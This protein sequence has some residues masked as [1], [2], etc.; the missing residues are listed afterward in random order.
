MQYTD[1]SSVDNW[2]N[3]LPKVGSRGPVSNLV[4]T[5]IADDYRE[6]CEVISFSPKA[7]AALSRRCLQNILR[8]NGYIA[9]DLSKE[10]SLFLDEADTSKAPSTILRMTVD[11]I[12]NF[13]NFSAHPINDVTSLQIIDVE[14]EEAEWC[15]EIIEEMFD[16]FYVRPAEAAA[17]KRA[18]D[19]KLKAAGKPLSK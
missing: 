14:P 18:L 2:T 5:S 7:S 17:R 3:L 15:L 19:E 4:P 6:A 1:G 12:R 9:K 8:A 16:H 11:A 13:G 10:I